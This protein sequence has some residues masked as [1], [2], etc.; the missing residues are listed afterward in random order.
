MTPNLGIF[1][2]ALRLFVGLI[3]IVAPIIDFP[4]IWENASYGYVSMSI[5][6]VLFVTGTLRFCPLYRVLGLS[7]CK[8]S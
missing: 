3:L 1:D 4:S 2:R 7:T 6:A 8:T 5:G